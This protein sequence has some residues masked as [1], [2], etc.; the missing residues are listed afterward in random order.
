MRCRRSQETF[1]LNNE[2][3]WYAEKGGSD[4]GRPITTL[5]MNWLNGDNYEKADGCKCETV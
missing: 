4:Y 1:K 3:K 5:D 2:L